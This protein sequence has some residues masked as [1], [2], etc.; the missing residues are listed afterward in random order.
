MYKL[1]ILLD[2]S[3][4]T[5]AKKLAFFHIVKITKRNLNIID[6]K[7]LVVKDI[8]DKEVGLERLFSS[9]FRSFH[10]SL[11]AIYIPRDE[12]LSRNKY[13][14]FARQNSEQI[15]TGNNTLSKHFLLSLQE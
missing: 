5:L 3:L 10:E 1:N 9:S 8:H 6:G 7:I 12:I 4:S 13:Q 15:F 14:W 11:F 2:N